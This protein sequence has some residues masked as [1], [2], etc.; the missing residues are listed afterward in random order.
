M[1]NNK[2]T[3]IKSKKLSMVDT[4]DKKSTKR[5]ASAQAIIKF[6]KKVYKTIKTDGSPKGEIFS[7][8]RIAAIQGAKKT[9]ELIP[10]CHNIKIDFVSVMFKFIDTKHSVQ[11]NSI[12]KTNDNTGVEMEALT[13]VTIAALTIYDMCK[14][15]DKGIEIESINLISK[16]GGKSGFY[17]NDSI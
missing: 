6:K 2:F 12:V 1:N 17:N 3:H 10:L 15:I 8:A 14:S 11:I 5:E 7:T 13:T 4:S 16:S 9:N